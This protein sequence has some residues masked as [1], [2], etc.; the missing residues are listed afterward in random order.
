VVT[1]PETLRV[2]RVAGA[3][4]LAHLAEVDPPSKA[5]LAAADLSLLASISTGNE[6]SISAVREAA[7]MA[8]KSLHWHPSLQN[9]CKEWLL[10][11]LVRCTK[12][13]QLEDDYHL[14]EMLEAHPDWVQL[15][16]DRGFLAALA[17]II[18]EKHSDVGG[19]RAPCFS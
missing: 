4:T 14:I 18:R 16:V 6:L 8:S 3:I 7:L 17:G 19:M 11:E 9:H 13:G 2:T 1:D 5:Q 10:P 12:L 15:L